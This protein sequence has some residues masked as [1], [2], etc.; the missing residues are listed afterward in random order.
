MVQPRL[1]GN[2][3]TEQAGLPSRQ[4]AS[5]L[6]GN[7]KQRDHGDYERRNLGLGSA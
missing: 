1:E 6:L 4:G 2:R 3:R 5:L 7:G